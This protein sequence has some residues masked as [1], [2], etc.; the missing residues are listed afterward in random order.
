MI[1]RA[2]GDVVRVKPKRGV[3]QPKLKK[4]DGHRL[5]LVRRIAELPILLQ[6]RAW[7]QQAL[8]SLYDVHGVTIKRDIKVLSEYWPVERIKRGRFIEYRIERGAQPTLKRI[9][10]DRERNGTRGNGRKEP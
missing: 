8:A 6:E 5:A 2:G 1:G 3:Y 9:G 7:S 10:R 4:Q